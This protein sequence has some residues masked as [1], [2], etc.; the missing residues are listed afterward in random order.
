[1]RLPLRP[2]S[3]APA[4][5]LDAMLQN[6]AVEWVAEEEDTGIDS[7]IQSSRSARGA[8]GISVDGVTQVTPALAPTALVYR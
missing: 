8:R 4:Y 6:P 1:M 7:A 2:A 3:C 5:N